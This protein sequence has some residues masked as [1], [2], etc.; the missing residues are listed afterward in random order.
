[1]SHR[2]HASS[3]WWCLYMCARAVMFSHS[4]STLP[5]VELY[6]RISTD[7]WGPFLEHSFSH[8]FIG[9]SITVNNMWIRRQTAYPP[10]LPNRHAHNVHLHINTNRIIFVH[11][12]LWDTSLLSFKYKDFLFAKPVCSMLRMQDLTHVTFC[13]LI[14]QKIFAPAQHTLP[15]TGQQ[16]LFFIMNFI[17]VKHKTI[18][19][20][21]KQVLKTGAY[22]HACFFIMPQ[23]NCKFEKKAFWCITC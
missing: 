20:R 12:I 3:G 9:I 15:L 18:M 8:N 10:Y 11:T 22:T 21:I 6:W 17:L 5:L 19:T 13:N 23:Q 14:S 1:M 2:L 7:S 4:H 16:L